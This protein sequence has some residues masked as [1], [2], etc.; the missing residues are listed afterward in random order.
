MTSLNDFKKLAASPALAAYGFKAANA[1]TA[2]AATALLARMAGP[3]VVGNYSFAVVS[4]TLLAVIALHG[5]DQ[6]MLREVAGNLRQSNSGA[7]HGVLHFAVKSVALAALVITVLFLSVALEGHF[8]RW[9]AFNQAAMIGAAIGIGSAAFSRLGLAGLRAAGRPVA[10]QFWEGANS[11]LFAAIISGLW[12]AAWPMTAM[13]AVLLFFGCQLISVAVVWLIVS[14]EM[15]GWNA[16]SPADGRRLRASG[17]PIMSIQGLQGLQDWVMFALVAGITSA[18]AVGALRVA[19]QVVMVI[20]LVVSTGETF[21][22]ARVAGDFRAGRPDLVWRRHRRARLAMLLASAPLVLVCIIWPGVLLELAFGQGFI[23]AAPA[24]AVLAA[25]QATKVVAG[26]IGGLLFMSGHERWLLRFTIVGLALAV[27]TALWLV[28]VY[29][30]I[31]AAF[32]QAAST[33]FRSIASYAA[34]WIL[35]PKTASS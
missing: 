31:G 32:A 19:M 33:A 11:F 9:V 34:A 28:P 2:F 15:R 8:S 7:A 10:A 18:A 26:P 23:I 3:T 30:I 12:L 13:Y 17:F 14:K 6:V 1:L 24:L 21:I 20:T 29:G 35:I 25:G 16:A 27:G 5:L 4:A 22:A